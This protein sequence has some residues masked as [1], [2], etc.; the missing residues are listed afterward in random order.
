MAKRFT[1]G[2]A[3]ELLPQIGSWIR[4]AVKL[5]SEYAEAEGAFQGLLQRIMV[6]GGMVVDRD[7]AGEQKSRRDRAGE[8]LKAVIEN[9]HETGCVVKDL[10]LGLVDFPTLFRGEEVYLCW[11]MDEPDIRFW[12]GTQEGYAGRKPIDPEFLEHHRG[13]K[14]Q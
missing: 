8:R 6:S 10:D 2:E 1:L 12:H 9:I 7:S 11:K 13:D 4:E 14:T 3:Q 5:K